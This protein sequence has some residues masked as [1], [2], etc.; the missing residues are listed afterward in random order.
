MTTHCL[1]VCRW[2]CVPVCCQSPSTQKPSG[3]FSFCW[4]EHA[5]APKD[6]YPPLT[7]QVRTVLYNK[8]FAASHMSV[9]SYLIHRVFQREWHCCSRGGELLCHEWSRLS[10]WRPSHS[11]CPP[12]SPLVWGGVLQPKGSEGG[13]RWLCVFKWHQHFAWQKVIPNSC[14]WMFWG[15]C[16][17]FNVIPQKYFLCHGKIVKLGFSF[18][19]YIYVADILDHE[20]DVFERQEGEQLVYLKVMQCYFLSSV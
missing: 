5:C 11:D 14:F 13:G 20:I 1:F 3:D 19:R 7:P 15:C 2:L 8:P 10:Q 9:C 4:G 16:F 17:F 12:G 6:Y 18:Y